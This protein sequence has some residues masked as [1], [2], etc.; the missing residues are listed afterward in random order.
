[1]DV[2][3]KAVNALEPGGFI[4]LGDVRNLSLLEAFYTGLELARSPDFLTTKQLQQKIQQQLRQEKQLVI[5]PAF[6]YALKTYLPQITQVEV[7]L[8]R[9]VHQNELTQFRYDVIL[10]TSPLTAPPMEISWLDWQQANLSVDGIKTLLNTQH[11]EVLGV[12]NIPNNRVSR[13]IQAMQMLNKIQQSTTIGQLRQDLRKTP[14]VGID[15]ET[16]WTISETL[17]YQVEIGWSAHCVE[18]QFY[19]LFKRHGLTEKLGTQV[20]I[21]MPL[22]SDP[23]VVPQHWSC[24]ANNPQQTLTEHQLGVALQKYL[25]SRLPSYMVPS[26]FICLEDLPL[27]ANG[28]IDRQALPSPEAISSRVDFMA[29]R[30]EIEETIAIAWQ[31][32]LGLQTIS[33]HDNFFLLGGHSLL[34]TQIISRLHQAYSIEIPLRFIFAYPT[35]AQLAEH[36]EPL[37]SRKLSSNTPALHSVSR[38]TRCRE[39]IFPLSFAQ[40]RL[41]FLDQLQPG[42]SSYNTSQAVRLVGSLNILALEQSL[43]EIVNRHEALRTTFSLHNGQAVQIIHP[44]M[45][46]EILKVDLQHQSLQAQEQDI[47]WWTMQEIHR[48]FDLSQGPLLNVTLLILSKTEHVFLLTLHH[49]ITDGWSMSLVLQ[50]MAALYTARSQGQKLMLP[51]LPIQYAD[52]ALWQRE[53]LQGDRL[54]TQLTYWT[55]Q[56][57]NLPILKLPTDHPPSATPIRNGSRQYRLFPNALVETLKSIHQQ[58]GITLFMTLTAAFKVWLYHY[59]GQSDIVVGTDIANRNQA[60][61]ENLIGFFVNQLVLRTQLRENPTF[62]RVLEQVREVMLDAYAHQDLPF[63]KLVEVLNPT[64]DLSQTPLFQAKIILDPPQSRPFSLP[65][66]TLHPIKIE[67]KTVQFDLLLAFNETEQGLHSVWEYNSDLF[68]VSTINRMIEQFDQLLH[69]IAQDPDASL[70]DLKFTLA[71]AEMQ[72]QLTQ[73]QAYENTIQQQLTTL[74]RN[75]RSTPER[76]SS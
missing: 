21:A 73:V 25:A 66:L 53:W 54:E 33:V 14:E 49:I 26:A 4:F 48:T 36:L 55:Q 11:P 60:G 29:P 57:Q 42:D 50:E 64:R 44:E 8:E 3:K 13:E 46:L 74:R 5:D 27:T 6:F 30:T 65:G 40:Q 18:G 62:R 10:H 7:H 39:K 69:H 35:I 68:E 22:V 51:E 38:E 56:L 24:Y 47:A 58:E 45:T 41:W 34:A 37:L 76:S 2:V 12:I 67:R 72:Q 52:F 17:P 16:L 31:Q 59:T 32:V 28:K 71:E 1:M 15:P 9:G 61:T 43:Q 75:R 19:A 63:E 70:S 23:E 20:S